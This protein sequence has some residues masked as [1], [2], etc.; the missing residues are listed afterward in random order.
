MIIFGQITSIMAKKDLEIRHGILEGR[1]EVEYFNLTSIPDNISERTNNCCNYEQIMKMIN[2][3]HPDCITIYPEGLNA[4]TLVRLL[5][6][7]HANYSS[8]TREIQ[9]GGEFVEKYTS[10]ELILNLRPEVR[11]K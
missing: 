11:G 8:N 10:Y 4:V 3:T 2:K 6:D 5:H 9:R 1:K 7:T